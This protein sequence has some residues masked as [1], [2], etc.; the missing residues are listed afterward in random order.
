MREPV[1]GPW[2]PARRA[3]AGMVPIG[4]PRRALGRDTRE[5]RP[6]ASLDA[7]FHRPRKRTIQSLRACVK[8][9]LQ[10]RGCPSRVTGCPAFAGMTRMD[11]R[12][13]RPA[14]TAKVAARQCCEECLAGA[15]S[16]GIWPLLELLR[17]GAE[18][19]RQRAQ[20]AGQREVEGG[21]GE[22][23]QGFRLPEQIIRGHG[24]FFPPR[25]ARVFVCHLSDVNPD[26]AGAFRRGSPKF[27]VI[28]QGWRG[29]WRPVP[30]C[31][32]PCIGVLPSPHPACR[33]WSDS[34]CRK[35][36]SPQPAGEG[37]GVGVGVG[38]HISRTNNYPPPHPSPTRGEGADRFA[39]RGSPHLAM[40]RRVKPGDDSLCVG[41][42]PRQPRD[43]DQAMT[44]DTRP[45]DEEDCRS[46]HRKHCRSGVGM[47]TFR[48]NSSRDNSR[49]HCC[50]ASR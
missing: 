26:G 49:C 47:T 13:Q 8:A 31:G 14:R 17:L 44:G 43:D 2:V 3:R 7:R 29:K 36:A 20:P 50:R 35:R 5:V 6:C 12:G 30:G 28:S 33:G 9:T 11:R 10:H 45:V 32:A 4:I 34:L 24:R 38:G 1:V 42:K 22:M 41:A 27:P 18:F 15:S 39:A 23:E 19:R 21:A 16:P 40:D 25:L 46:A 37:L 48:L